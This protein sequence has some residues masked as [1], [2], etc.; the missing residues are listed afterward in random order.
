[1]ILRGYQ[2][3]LVKRASKALQAK[4]N[5]L[6]VAATGAGKTIVMSALAGKVGGKTLILQHRD[7]LVSQ[8]MAKFT[9]INPSW[10]TSVFDAQSKDFSGQAT[11]A[12]VQSLSRRPSAIPVIDHLIIDEAHHA[13]SKTYLNLIKATKEKNPNVVMSGWTATP[14]R[15]DGIG[16]KRAGFDNCC[17]EV[18]IDD[19]VKLGFL[20]PPKAFVCMLDGVDLSEVSIK[21]TGEYDM[22]EVEELMDVEVH[23]DTVVSKW[24]ELAGNRKT[25]V[26]CSTVEHA[27]HVTEAYQK[28]GIV[29]ALLT[30][31]TPKKARRDMLYQFDRGDIQVICNVA[32]LTEGFDSQPVSCIVLLRP[33]SY[34][35]TMLQMIGRGLR[36]VDP[37]EYPEVEKTDCVGR[38]TL[39]LTN[40]GSVKIQ[41]ITL[42]FKVWDGIS[43]VKHKGAICKGL[44]KTITYQGLTATKDHEV[45]TNEGWKSFQEAAHRRLRI[46]KTGDGG[47]PIRFVD[48]N[49]KGNGRE[50]GAAKSR[51][52]MWK[53]WSQIY[54]FLY[55]FAQKTKHKSMS[56]LQ[57]AYED[58]ST[59]MAISKNPR[60]KKQMRQYK[61]Y[62][63]P[64]LWWK[65]HNVQVPDC[66]C[67]ICLDKREFGYSGQKISIRQSGQRWALRTWKS[68]LGNAGTKYEQFKKN[69]RRK[70][71]KIHELPNKPS[72]YKICGCNITWVYPQWLNRRRN[73]KKM[74]NPIEQ[75]EGEVWDILNAGP[76][77]RFTANGCLVHNCVILD[78]GETLKSSGGLYLKP[79]LDDRMKECPVCGSEV[80]PGTSICQIC[81]YEWLPPESDAIT[82]VQEDDAEMIRDVEMVEL[83]IL[84]QSPFQWSDIFHTGKV[85]IANGFDAMAGVVSADGEKFMAIGKARNQRVIRVLQK[86]RKPQCLSSADDFLRMNEDGDAA[87]KSKRWLKDQPTEKQWSLLQRAGYKRDTFNLSM[88]KYS[89]NCHLAFQWNRHAIEKALCV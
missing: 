56:K 17:D 30:G 31:E 35:S 77:Q 42:D 82:K 12:M 26:F 24:Q 41:D 32:V 55:Q 48:N 65:G 74:G 80:P 45:M 70:K 20:V 54:D 46:V 81:G 18:T 85:L 44:Q 63:I 13:C 78:F 14:A 23:N 51:S 40:R 43:F 83:D 7:E 69:K 62:K 47:E 16:L 59:K 1:M 4:K 88:T 71:K 19:L 25:I 79:R 66:Q 3:Q 27:T 61:R 58:G 53:M 38:D 50:V 75:T 72:R 6:A 36:T 76:L 29:A 52:P 73:Y 2:E 64:R 60:P 37:E 22:E 10:T 34:K 67:C 84:R 68:A 15:S 11:F 33:C 57:Y 89:A 9:M 86:G 39:V 87:R 21:R 8:N 49:I 28:A 5:T